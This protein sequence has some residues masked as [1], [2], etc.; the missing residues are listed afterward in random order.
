MSTFTKKRNISRVYLFFFV[1]E[2]YTLLI[3][4][5]KFSN[6][7]LSD[8]GRVHEVNLLVNRL[9]KYRRV[10]RDPNPRLKLT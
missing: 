3:I 8:S 4:N 2:A 1:G 5:Y 9:V 7:A 6:T 10:A